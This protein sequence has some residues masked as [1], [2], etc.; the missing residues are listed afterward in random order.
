MKY[1]KNFLEQFS[2]EGYVNLNSVVDPHICASLLSEIRGAQEFS[3]KIFMD[4]KSFLENPEYTGV[5]PIPGRNIIEQ[6]EELAT[7][8]E[9]TTEVESLLADLLGEGYVILRKKVICGVP[10]KWIPDWVLARIR[11]N[12]V[13]NLGTYIKPEYRNITYF[14]GIDFHQDIIDLAGRDLDFITLYVY[15]HDVVQKDAPLILLS[16]SHQFGVDNFP[17]ELN[18]VDESEKKWR[19]VN[20][21]SGKSIESNQLVITGNAG[22]VALWHSCTL[23]G[24]QPNY[25]D[26]ERISLRYL[27]AKAPGNNDTF[28]DSVNEGIAK[29]K[30]DNS[31]RVDQTK[32]CEPCMKKNHLFGQYQSN[33]M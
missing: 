18:L 8:I 19:Y 29:T 16:G 2:T 21:E 31:M 26:E 1:N 13:N 14:Y 33:K 23:H 5:N 6:Y 4:E 25:G 9:G 20:S 3:S 28:L 10:E 32:N 7:S 11:E 27:I 12:A 22:N 24:T 30:F 17:H 15:L